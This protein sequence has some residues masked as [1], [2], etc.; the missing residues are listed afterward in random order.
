MIRIRIEFLEEQD[1]Q[2]I[3]KVLDGKYKIAEIGRAHV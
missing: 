1:R 2:E 3:L